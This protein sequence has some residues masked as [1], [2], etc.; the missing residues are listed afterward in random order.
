MLHLNILYVNIIEIRKE[1][2]NGKK[3]SICRIFGIEINMALLNYEFDR[4]LEFERNDAYAEGFLRGYKEG[5][6]KEI[7]WRLR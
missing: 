2:G 3:I 1:I 4:Q 7:G 6:E 5:F